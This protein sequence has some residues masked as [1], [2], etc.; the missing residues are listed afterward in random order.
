MQRRNAGQEAKAGGCYRPRLIPLI[1]LFE[2]PSLDRGSLIPGLA[3][4]A[5]IPAP[6]FDQLQISIWNGLGPDIVS[7]VFINAF[8]N[9][10]HDNEHDYLNFQNGIALSLR[11]KLGYKV[12]RF[13][14]TESLLKELTPVLQSFPSRKDGKPAAQLRSAEIAWDFPVA[15]SAN[16]DEAEEQLLKIVA[17]TVSANREAQLQTKSS[18]YIH[19]CHDGASNGLITFY[20]H[21]LSKYPEKEDASQ[22]KAEGNSEQEG[23]TPRFSLLPS[24]KAIWRGKAYGKRLSQKMPWCVRFEVTLLGQ[25]LEAVIGKS[26]PADL[27]TLPERLAGLGFDNFWR[28]E[29]FNWTGFMEAARRS[30]KCKGIPFA[31]VE[32][33][34]RVSCHLKRL[35]G[36]D[37]T[38]WSKSVAIRIANVIGSKRLEKRVEEKEFSLPLKFEDVLPG[39]SFGK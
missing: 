14:A 28:F 38:M 26:L 36:Q 13:S 12:I 19:V 32:K 10:W 39:N 20:F 35:Q 9:P 1:K 7:P 3:P 17:V 33:R 2:S 24:K 5:T 21:S 6:I 18:E 27:T 34:T 4:A 8:G 31:D 37:V 25:K 22:N 23:N 16:Y 15:V 29:R 30:A 11:N